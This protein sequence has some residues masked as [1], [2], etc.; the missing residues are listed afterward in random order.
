MM[1]QRSIQ[2]AFQEITKAV[3]E[4]VELLTQLDQQSGDGNLGVSM[5]SGFEA[6]NALVSASEETDCG[7]LLNAAANAFNQAAPSSLG[8]I[9]TFF[10]KGMARGLRGKQRFDRGE[11]ASAMQC[12][13]SNV[14]DK[15]GSKPGEKTILD[16][17]VPGVSAL[18]EDHPSNLDAFSAA[19][20]AAE[21]G[22][23]AT[24]AMKAVWGRAAYYGEQSIGR[25]DG[26]AVVGKLIFQSLLRAVQNA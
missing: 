5:R 6:A 26:G 17:L 18:A 12:G 15:A 11:L 13:L 19:A 4:Q 10:C 9:L 2:S 3:S 14:M 21:S 23:E 16:S 1:N 8:T 22:A 20:Q 24:R 7:L 25:I